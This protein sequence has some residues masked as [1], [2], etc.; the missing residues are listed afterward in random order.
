MS[1]INFHNRV[2]SSD[3]SNYLIK[4]RTNSQSYPDT[5]YRYGDFV[6]PLEAME[7]DTYKGIRSA[8]DEQ[9]HRTANGG[10]LVRNVIGNKSHC[11]VTIRS[12][13]EP[14]VT[15][16]LKNIFGRKVLPDGSNDIKKREEV[17]NVNFWVPKLYTYVEATCYVP[18]IEFTIKKAERVM[19][20]GSEKLLITYD[21][22]TLEFI[23]Y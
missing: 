14:V 7:Y 4:V 20:S 9:S 8:L 11:S 2:P 21:S 22:F 18:E 12:L 1:E 5:D 13:P 6:I 10:T 19:V 16:I 23:E 15:N 17:V 3:M